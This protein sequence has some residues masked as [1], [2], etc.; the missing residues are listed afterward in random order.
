MLMIDD[1]EARRSPWLFGIEWTLVC[2][3]EGIV[4]VAVEGV[5]A[6]ACFQPVDDQIINGRG[7]DLV[8][9]FKAIS[10]E[11]HADQGSDGHGS[12]EG[13]GDDQGRVDRLTNDW[14]INCCRALTWGWYVDSV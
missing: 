7:E 13:Q 14:S 8:A 4:L 9:D 5:R 3:R 11:N 12:D 6:L 2:E 1:L 10:G